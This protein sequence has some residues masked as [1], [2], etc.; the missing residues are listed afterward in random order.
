MTNIDDIILLRSNEL[1]CL[2]AGCAS[3]NPVEVLPLISELKRMDLTDIQAR[4]FLL[5]LKSHFQELKSAD[6][7]TQVAICV[8]VAEKL[9][10]FPEYARW[11][12][13]LEGNSLETSRQAIEEIRNLKITLDTLVRLK[14]FIL[15][16]EG[17]S[18]WR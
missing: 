13:L 1:T 16:V 14:P 11:L 3:I 6:D 12:T 10:Y 17:A 2:L 7:D 4:K 15:E 5:C 8:G 9:G 18:E